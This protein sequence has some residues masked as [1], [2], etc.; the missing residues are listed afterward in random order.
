[1]ILEYVNMA[2]AKLEE[3]TGITG[4][5]VDIAK[6]DIDAKLKLK[7][8]KRE[9]IFWVVAK[10][11][12]RNHQ[13]H[14]IKELAAEYK[15]LIIVA[16]RIFPKIKE[17]LRKLQIAYLE[18]NGNVYIQNDDTL[19]LI[20][21]QKPL[22]IEKET[23]NRA[24]AKTGLKL[25]FHL[26]LNNEL[27]NLP[28]RE[29]TEQTGIPFTNL[30]YIINGLKTK[31][32]ISEVNNKKMKL[33]NKDKLTKIWIERYDDILKPAL[34]IGTFSFAE[35]NQF[36]EWKKIKFKYEET[37]WGAEPAAAL[38]TKYLNPEILTIYTNEK[39]NELIKNY[40]LL[41]D[42]DGNIKIYKRF[43]KY[44][45]HDN[46][47]APELLIYADLINSNDSRN[48]ETAKMIYDE[49]IKDKN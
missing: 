45:E 38:I 34:K 3:L 32:Y 9:V 30:P 14:N 31:G 12:L 49:Y 23:V 44:N 25:I 22:P 19:I 18:A 17:E 8:N 36:K 47:T 28:Y 5:W 2:L 35:K 48:F 24:F 10:K 15:P 46:K 29:I 41:P 40:K 33:T 13:L 1:M 26:L 39:R 21:N 43:W 16:N 11:E 4:K 20:D 27:I 6:K 37:V 42:N 7:I